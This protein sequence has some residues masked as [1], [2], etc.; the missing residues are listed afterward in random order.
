MKKFII[1]ESE[2]ESIKNMY[3]LKEDGSLVDSSVDAFKKIL[4]MLGDA[5]KSKDVNK[6]TPTKK[7]VYNGPKGVLGS[8]W[9]SCKAWR[10][11]GGLGSFSENVHV[12]K[13]SNQFKITYTGP[14]SGLSLAHAANGKD[15]IHQLYNILICELNPLLYEGNLKPNIDNIKTEGGKTGKKST[16]TIT[17]PLEHSEDTYQLDRRGGWGHDPGSSKMANKCSE[18]KSKGGKCFGPVKNV[19]QARFG[20]ITEYFITYTI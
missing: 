10:S 3:D 8:E 7:D 20:K 11:K 1:T 15:T 9:K 19:V 5:F 6:P 14:S 16:L 2:K 4:S 13:S 18:I 12:D 17:V